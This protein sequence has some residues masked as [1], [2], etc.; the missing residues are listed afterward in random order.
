VVARRLMASGNIETA[1]RLAAQDSPGDDDEYT[2]AQFLAGYITLRFRKDAGAAF[3]HFARI[4]ARTTNP[5]IK[6]RA[7]YWAG[8]AAAKS[9][10]TDLA[11]K[12]YAV[13]A[14]H[15]TTFYGQL[16]AHELGDDAPPK[17]M[18]ESRPTGAEKARFEAQEMVRA[19]R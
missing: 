1:Y 8:R 10:N 14:E 5:D 19:A 15:R 6:G 2:E 17:P 4:I 7:A 3:D 18:P 16:S 9:G 11:A 12:W 13:G